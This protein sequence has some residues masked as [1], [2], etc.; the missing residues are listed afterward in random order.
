MKLKR[1]LIFC[2]VL[3]SSV[4]LMAQPTGFVDQL[5]VGGWDNAVGMTFDENGRIYVYEKAGRVWIVENGVKLNTPLIDISEEV[6]DWRDFGFLGFALD[7]NFLSNGYIYMQYTVDRHHL[8]NFGTSNYNPNTNEYFNATIGRITRY[9]AQASTGFTTVDYNSRK[10]LVGETKETG[11]P[12]LHESHGIGGIVFGTDG[13]LIAAAGDGASY[14]SVDE[15]SAGE[16]YYA[17]A[18]TDGIIRADE[19]VGAYRSQK[20]NS[21]NGKILR[22]D[23]ATGDGVPSNPFYQS[24]DPRSAQSRIWSTGV[25]NPYRITKQPNTGS[26]IQADGNP[27]VFYF[28]DVGWGNREELDIIP[29]GGLNFGWPKY[30]GMTYEPGYN[31]PAYNPANHE[32]PKVDWRTGTPRA[33]VNGNIYNVGST[34][35]PGPTFNGNASTGGAFYQGHDFPA[36]Y[37]DTY[38]HADYGAGWIRHFSFDTNGNPTKVEDFISNGGPI[39]FLASDHN[40]DGLFYVKYPDEIR[41]VVYNGTGNQNP[42]A[43]INSNQDFGPSPLSIQ[44]NGDQSFDP[45]NANLSYVWNFGDGTTS[46]AINPSHTYTQSNGNPNQY[47]VTLTVTDEVGNTGQAAKII[48]I[49]NTPPVII[50]TSVDNITSFDPTTS[51]T[52][53][54]NAVVNDAEHNASQLTYAWNTALYHNNHF[55]AEPI[56]NNAS[57]STMLSPIGCDGATYWYRIT[58]TVTD[59]AGLSSEV[60]QDIFPNCSGANQ[61]I[62][63][64]S[65]PGKLVTDAPFTV[66]ATATSGLPVTIYAVDGPASITNGVVTLQGI[67]GTVTL[68]A[69]QGGNASFAPALPI[70]QQFEVSADAPSNCSA[71]GT[72][73]LE[74]WTGISGLQV[75]NIP[76]NTTPNSTTTINQFEIPINVENYYGVR[77]RGYFCAPQ[78]GS[79]KFWI[80]SDDNGELWVSSNDN[81]ANKSLIASVPGWTS[82]QIWDKYPEQESA[83]IF[84]VKDQKYYIEALMKEQQG[85]DNLAVGWQLPDGTLERPMQGTYLSPFTTTLQDQTI[86]FPAIA[87][88]QTNDNPFTISAN[89]SSGLPVSFTLLSGPATLSGNTI[90]LT[91]TTG[92][93]TI[94]ASQAGN[95][96]YNSAPDVTQSFA[97]NSAGLQD[98]TI[99]FNALPDRVTTD[100]PFTIAASASSGLNVSFSVINGPATIAG[101]TVTLTGQTG[102]VTIQASQAGNTNYNPAPNV[103]QSFN[104]NSSGGGPTSY[105][106][107]IGNLPW[108]EWIEQVTFGTIDNGSFKEQYGDFTNL[109]TDVS[110]GQSYPILLDPG[111]SWAG[112]Q[113]NLFWK[114]WID[115]NQDGDFNDS[116]EEVLTANNGNNSVNENIIIPAS[117]L[118]GSTRMRVSMKKDSYAGPCE[119]FG[120]GEVEDYTVNIIA[121]GGGGPTC[122]NVTDGGTISGDQISCDPFD[123]ATISNVTNPAGGSGGLEYQWQQSTNSSTGPWTSAGGSTSSFN[124]GPITQT[125]WYRRQARR[126]G[127][128]TYDGVSNVIVKTIDNCPPVGQYCTAIGN[129][130]WQ[131]WIDNVTFG[132]INNS[133]FK[134]LYGDYTNLVTE[135]AQG[136]SL[137]IDLNPGLS[138]FGH[139][140]DLF[141]RVWID[142]NMDGDFTDNG[143]LV[144]EANNGRDPVAA[145]VNIPTDAV[146]GLTRMRVAMKKDSYAQSCESFSVGE[147]EDYS[148]NIVPS[149]T[150]SNFLAEQILSL[151]AEREQMAVQLEWMTNT[152]YKNDY[153]IVQRSADGTYFE[154]LTTV[155]N[156]YPGKEAFSFFFTDKNPLLGNNHYRIKQIHNDGSF[157]YSSTQ[158][159]EFDDTKQLVVFPNPTATEIFLSIKSF[160]GKTVNIQIFNNLGQLMEERL[161]QE[162]TED[163]QHFI[164]DGYTDGVYNITV[165][166]EGKKRLSTKFIISKL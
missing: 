26:H 93:V 41:R 142:F 38:F 5:F 129:Q 61:S 52:I 50:S 65:L 14:G 29:T 108:Q 147:V 43:S 140:T 30:E 114:V 102:I 17:Q 160:V 141:W 62:T 151:V 81:P 32:R 18:L 1:L 146:L 8:M 34:Q 124:P 84:L 134:E 122:S 85:G 53:N 138:W 126:S 37:H 136:A 40:F 67:P 28:G 11:I 115:F 100:A 152:G 23:P 2:G 64:T 107:S 13:T 109:T 101:N 79:Y 4:Y 63:F 120:E 119:S 71:T 117:A 60:Y 132:S 143:E 57:T 91:G 66:S 88:K 72:I 70:E 154:A 130:P 125:T 36:S 58:L 7:P 49:N 121:S 99:T 77:V 9:T 166:T 21:L 161:V 156:I 76:T 25:R 159:V 22:I 96:N 112:H 54:L 95:A 35:V 111:L 113:T 74:K 89:A 103:N 59:A 149:T 148:V 27:G 162:L 104:V 83:S 51:T 128:T 44:F 55:H 16:T 87:D 48:S 73:T 127:C 164:L 82:S 144:V 47:N 3:C 106:N 97:V 116:G 163:P 6:G 157:K 20:L 39:V 19:N 139:Q 137:P 105:C 94:R 42:I 15:G 24:S 123:P 33:L 135:A 90:T 158:L 153:F 131:E 118:T 45:E 110:Q 12:S 145:I 80:A 165:K 133:S 155:T 78:T 69:V 31:D 68:R 56:D 86:T 92:T 98:Q 150:A 46:T 75:S 10:V